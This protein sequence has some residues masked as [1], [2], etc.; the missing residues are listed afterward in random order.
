[1]PLLRYRLPLA[2]FG[3]AGAHAPSPQS[4]PHLPDLPPKP[5]GRDSPPLCNRRPAGPCPDRRAGDGARRRMCR[6]RAARSTAKQGN[7]KDHG[8]KNTEARHTSTKTLRHFNLA[9]FVATSL[10]PNGQ[11]G[12]W[13]GAK[14]PASSNSFAGFMAQIPPHQVCHIDGARRAGFLHHRVAHWNK[15]RIDG[16][17]YCGKRRESWK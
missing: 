17:V 3:R 6:K 4:G 5:N 7:R 2:L 11:R 16:R 12:R 1:M 8:C 10:P 13:F 9:E 14:S 15:R